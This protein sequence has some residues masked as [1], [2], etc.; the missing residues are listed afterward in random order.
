MGKIMVAQQRSLNMR[1]ELEAAKL[2]IAELEARIKQLE[3]DIAW[4][5]EEYDDGYYD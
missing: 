3:D 5:K 2:R 4:A 1:N